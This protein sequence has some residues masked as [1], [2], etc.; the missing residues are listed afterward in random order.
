MK[1]WVKEL[2]KKKTDAKEV[3]VAEET[4]KLEEFFMNDPLGSVTLPPDSP[5][6]DWVTDVGLA[7]A[8][9]ESGKIKV[10]IPDEE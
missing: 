1:D 9:D 5:L 2:I 6:L 10:S 8:I 4:E 7:M 3:F